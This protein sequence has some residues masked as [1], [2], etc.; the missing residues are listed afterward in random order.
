MP[1]TPRLSFGSRHH[2]MNRAARRRRVFQDDLDLF[3]DVL[4][5]LPGRFGVRIHGWALMSNHYHLML[6]V[7]DGALPRVMRQLGGLLAERLNRKHGW[8]GP[9]FRGRYR[10]RVV[11]DD[12]YW[13][14]LLAYLHLNP[15][16]AGLVARPEDTRWTS[17]RAYLGL[18]EKPPW[19][20]CEELLEL[21][22]SPEILAAEIGDLA[23]GRTRLPDSFGPDWLWRPATT[24][25][26]V[27]ARVP[28]PVS[29]LSPEEAMA[30]VQIVTGATE[31][32]LRRSQIGR[33]GHAAR[34]LA[35]WW[36]LETTGLPRADVG[37]RLGMSAGAVG[38]AAWRVRAAQEEP[39]AG[40]RERML[41]E[42]WAPLGLESIRGEMTEFVDQE[43]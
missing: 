28:A 24:A 8:D 43:W 18:D 35:A 3:L 17:H 29:A 21:Y 40:W 32:A 36:M 11:A 22:G 31:E 19:L 14:T 15:V 10:N 9:L 20:S 26:E 13:R 16:S 2:V 27:G 5:S 34:A 41:A 39:V 38:S 23:T 12:T 1:R 25:G 4:S 30:Q 7:P 33:P 6:E 37:A 42:R